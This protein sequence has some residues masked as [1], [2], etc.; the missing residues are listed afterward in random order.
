METALILFFPIAAIS[1]SILLA[2]Y[3]LAGFWELIVITTVVGGF[4]WVFAI[5]GVEKRACYAQ[6]SRAH[7]GQSPARSSRIQDHLFQ[8]L[9][10]PAG[11]RLYALPRRGDLCRVGCRMPFWNRSEG[12]SLERHAPT[13]DSLIPVTGRARRQSFS[14]PRSSSGASAIPNGRRPLQ[15]WVWQSWALGWGPLALTSLSGI[16]LGGESLDS[17]CLA[18]VSDSIRLA[19]SSCLS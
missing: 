14:S 5:V 6:G 11:T 18:S 13:N 12:R 1:F 8:D 16:K 15:K 19:H 3:T 7:A 4:F 17:W 2:D 10:I 9:A